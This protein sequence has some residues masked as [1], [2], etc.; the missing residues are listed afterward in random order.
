MKPA[1]YKGA[2]GGRGSGKSHF[3]AELLVDE[4]L[5]KPGFRA[6]CV[7]EVQK[8]LAESAKKLI[9][10]K[11][12]ALGL[13]ESFEVQKDRIITPGNG[14][15]LFQGMQDH[16][17]ESIKSLEGMDVAWVEE[18]QTLSDRSLTLLRPT[19]RKE[20]SEIWAS[21][22]PRR[23]ADAIDKFLRG[24]GVPED[25]IIVRANWSD[26][27]W[28][29]EVLNDERLHDL[30]HYPDRY[31]HVWEGEYATIVEGAYYA[32]DLALA[33]Q[34]GRIGRVTND[35]LLP[36]R[37]YHDLAFSSSDQADAYTMWVVQ[38]VDREIRVLAYYET[39]G[40]SLQHHVRWIQDWMRTNDVSHVVHR[41]PHDGSR[42]DGLGLRFEDHWRSAS[43]KEY[44]WT[45]GVIPNQ[46][47]GAAMQRVEAARRHFNKVW[48]NEAT[49]EAGR[50]ALAFYHERIDEKRQ[51]GL[52][53]DHDWSSHGADAFGL[54]ASDY[55][56]RHGERPK[57]K[58]YS[59]DNSN[60]SS[61]WAW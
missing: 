46:G 61:A 52:G 56:E 44:G 13:G 12:Q 38:F 26:N 28:F 10:D 54:M 42:P 16:N 35:P 6:V 24:D 51:I 27:P 17:A 29:P 23:K 19:I 20:G 53:P 11:I 48:F 30:D 57:P 39:Q 4:A 47:K 50:E 8:T 2:W 40:Q 43:T 3:F 49:T 55:V 18:A 14:S 31:P 60:S 1:R 58:D 37:V 41:L 21:W 25:A 15:I 45:V 5:C 32:K 59:F 22:N 34:Q 33:R 7:R 36:V 9:E